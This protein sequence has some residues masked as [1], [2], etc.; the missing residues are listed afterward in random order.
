MSK[1]A[2]YATLFLEK[3]S[4]IL[5]VKTRTRLRKQEALAD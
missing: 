1:N 3:G 4:R 5:F 2:S